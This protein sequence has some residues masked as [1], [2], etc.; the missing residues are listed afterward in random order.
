MP[1]LPSKTESPH[2]APRKSRSRR[3]KAR[4]LVLASLPTTSARLC[5]VAFFG[6]GSMVGMAVLSGLAGWP[7]ARLG[8]RPGATRILAG[9]TGIFSMALAI[10]WA[11]P[12][13]DRLSR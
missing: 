6:A 5:Y 8:R 10:V 12:L 4:N 9:A 7:L 2:Q 11:W 1:A 3:N 13:F